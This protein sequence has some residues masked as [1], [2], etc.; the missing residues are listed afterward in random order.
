MAT[1]RRRAVALALLAGTLGG[2]VGCSSARDSSAA[3][4]SVRDEHGRSVSV[5]DLH[6]RPAL[7]TSWATWCHNCKTLLPGL[8]SLA[9]TQGD[10]GLQVIAVNVNALGSDGEVAS[11]E[12]DYGMTM[13]RWRDA[14]DDFTHEFRARGVPTS[15]LLDADGRV[16]QQWPGGIP[17]DDPAVDRR[18]ARL[19]ERSAR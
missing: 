14:D 15:V 1:L 18:I 19:V 12:R 7:L 9:E 11:V 10:H 2:L 6:G 3:R 17:L 4:Y 8:Q 5:A 13:P 16:V